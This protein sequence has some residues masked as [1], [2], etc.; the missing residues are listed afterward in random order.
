M[1]LTN[2]AASGK[3]IA[4]TI[5][6]ESG[7]VVPATK[8]VSARGMLG[9]SGKAVEVAISTISS[10]THPCSLGLSENKL[11]IRWGFVRKKHETI[12]FQ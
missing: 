4:A 1:V 6:L 11:L 3:K 12:V 9:I 5:K 2:N 8:K 7:R 10:T